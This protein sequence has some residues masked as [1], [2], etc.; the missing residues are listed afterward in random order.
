MEDEG[1]ADE[2]KKLEEAICKEVFIS[3]NI[4]LI[5]YGFLVSIASY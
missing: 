5:H 2:I 4:I 3:S 1:I